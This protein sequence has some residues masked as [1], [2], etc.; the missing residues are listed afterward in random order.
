[1][2]ISAIAPVPSAIGRY[3][4]IDDMST[5]LSSGSVGGS[6]RIISPRGSGGPGWRTGRRKITVV[7]GLSQGAGGRTRSFC[8]PRRQ[9]AWVRRPM[10][11]PVAAANLLSSPRRGRGE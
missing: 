7:M 9:A 6:C 8:V 10:F 3:V 5:P 1:M 2:K 11:G 4:S